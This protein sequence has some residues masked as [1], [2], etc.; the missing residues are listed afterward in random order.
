MSEANHGRENEGSSSGGGAEPAPYLAQPVDGYGYSGTLATEPYAAQPQTVA[1]LTAF[2]HMVSI[3]D[4]LN[5]RTVGDFFQ[6][7]QA[8]VFMI[9]F[10]MNAHFN[11]MDASQLTRYMEEHTANNS[12]PFD[13]WAA[14]AMWR[15]HLV[16]L[17]AQSSEGVGSNSANVDRQILQPQMRMLIQ[18]ALRTEKG[19]MCFVRNAFSHIARRYAHVR[20]IVCT[21]NDLSACITV[22]V[23]LMYFQCMVCHAMAPEV[24]PSNRPIRQHL[25]CT[26]HDQ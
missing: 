5:E 7:R 21:F 3:L 8:G 24:A 2:A 12:V 22:P 25:L 26:K 13:S 14:Q 4:L 6:N 1:P 10:R 23:E 20:V 9:L 17:L 11:T 19:L 15:H 16:E 18:L